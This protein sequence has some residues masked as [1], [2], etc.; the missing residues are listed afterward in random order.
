MNLELMWEILTIKILIKFLKV[1]PNLDI[2]SNKQIIKSKFKSDSEEI[3]S[4]WF[5]FMNWKMQ[6]TGI[7]IHA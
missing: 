1:V 7:I 6:L 2:E 3:N 5:L 4:T